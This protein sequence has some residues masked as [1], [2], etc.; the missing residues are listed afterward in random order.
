MNKIK[1]FIIIF[2]FLS[3]LFFLYG[4]G[5]FPENHQ[6]QDFL[7]SASNSK[8]DIIIIFNSGGWGNTPFEK[9]EDFAPIVEGVQQL[10]NEWGHNSIIVPYVRAKGDF[11]SKVAATREIFFS[12]PDQG[13]KMAGEIN[14]FLKENPGKKIIVAGLSSGAAFADAAIEKVSQDV[15]DRVYAIEIGNPF[16]KKHQVSENVLRLENQGEDPLSRGEMKILV[17]N[18]LKALSKWILVK[19]SGGSQTFAK[20]LRLP[21]HEYRWQEIKPE[22][23]DFLENKFK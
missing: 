9:A 19:I 7:T 3:G 14:S 12:F 5:F 1:Y 2:V 10:L 20:L 13:E 4:P 15:K 17:P 18:F 11:L 22:V 23:A 8:D 6:F 21:G 16:W